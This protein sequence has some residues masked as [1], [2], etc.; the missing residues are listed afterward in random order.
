MQDGVVRNTTPY[1]TT[2]KSQAQCNM[3]VDLNCDGF[4]EPWE[5]VDDGPRVIYGALAFFNM[6]LILYMY[7]SRAYAETYGLQ[8]TDWRHAG[9]TT[10]YL[11]SLIFPTINVIAWVVSYAGGDALYIFYMVSR[12]TSWYYVSGFWLGPIFLIIWIGVRGITTLTDD[13]TEVNLAMFCVLGTFTI[14]I[15]LMFTEAFDNWMIR[16]LYVSMGVKDA[17]TRVKN[18]VFPLWGE[19]DEKDVKTTEKRDKKYKTQ[20]YKTN[21]WNKAEKDSNDVSNAN[22]FAFVFETAAGW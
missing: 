16:T 3:R 12:I 21:E 7:V 20:D 1:S 14:F 9:M 11:L 15:N 5:T 22:N 19:Y 10:S 8:F 13:N 18:G 2:Y 6:A 17:K 4:I